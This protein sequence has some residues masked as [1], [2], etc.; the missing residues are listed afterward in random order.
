MHASGGRR[1]IPPRPAPG[2]HRRTGHTAL[3]F[4]GAAEP[5][6][7]TAAPGADRHSGEFAAVT[8]RAVFAQSTAEPVR[9]Q[10]DHVAGT[11]QP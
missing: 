7:T 6:R 1:A 8:I 9:T 10:P 5:R 3:R 2:T 4:S 11:A